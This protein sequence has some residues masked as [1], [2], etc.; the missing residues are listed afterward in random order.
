MA[1]VIITNKSDVIYEMFSDC[2]ITT[3]STLDE[4]YDGAELKIKVNKGMFNVYSVA[5]TPAGVTPVVY[6]EEH[7]AIESGW[8]YDG[9]NFTE[10]TT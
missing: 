6:N 4:V 1:D 10:I 8:E 9:T 5:S 3:G 7:T 2:T